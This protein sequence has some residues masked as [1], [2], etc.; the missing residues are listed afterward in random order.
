MIF[1][2]S[3][4]VKF[5][6]T[7]WSAISFDVVTCNIFIVFSGVFVCTDRECNII[8]GSCQEFLNY[9]GMLS[10]SVLYDQLICNYF[11]YVTVIIVTV[12]L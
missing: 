4:V 11:I 10:C 9:P 6:N 7:F 3:F 1:I 12:S 2:G 8:L 5:V